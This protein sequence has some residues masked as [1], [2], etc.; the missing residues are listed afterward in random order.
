[1]PDPVSF[2]SA[3][4]R[5]ALPLLFAGQAQKEFHVNEAHAII[6]LLLH[7]AIAGEAG[8]PPV[9]PEEGECWLVSDTATGAWA[10]HA[11]DIACWSAGDW[12]F[13]KPRNGLRL[14]D[15]ASGQMR[16]YR[17]GAWTFSSPLE[18]PTGGSTVD[19]EARAAIGEL[20]A[21][22]ADAGILPA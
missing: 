19:E 21:A 1:M 6:D 17:A 9:S 5:Y 22:L 4:P 3:S 18:L 11:A 20:I 10:D 12:L 15:S 8:D 16:L 13:A 14:L 2:T 7:P